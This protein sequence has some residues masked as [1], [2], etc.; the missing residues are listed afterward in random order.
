MPFDPST[1]KD[2][3][4]TWDY[5]A[6]ELFQQ[7]AK[8]TTEADMFAFGTAVYEVVT[9]A[10]VF[11]GRRKVRAPLSPSARRKPERPSDPAAGGFGQGTWEFME[12]C[13]EE[14]PG[15]R[16]TAGEAVKHFERVAE[17]SKPVDRSPAPLIQRT[18][19]ETDSELDD[20]RSQTSSVLGPQASTST[21]NYNCTLCF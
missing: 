1:H 3:G 12:G 16:P 9:G 17:T 5:M 15:R 19:S 6:P 21:I 20:S 7:D 2:T 8:C 18:D 11:G 13:W 10:Q 4:G 14:N